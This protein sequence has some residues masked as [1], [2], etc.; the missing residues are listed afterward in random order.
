M[1]LRMYTR[2]AV[3]RGFGVEL[4]HHQEGAEAG[5]DGAVIRVDGE[6]AYAWLRGETGVHRIARVSPFGTGD[7]R[8]TSFAAVEV[9]PDVDEVAPPEIKDS[10]LRAKAICAGGPGGQ[11][12]NKV[13]TAIR[14]EHLPTG[15]VVL[16]RSERSH[17]QNRANALRLLQAKLAQID[18]DRRDEEAAVKRG[19]RPAIRFGHQRRS[20]VF[21]PKRLVRDERTEVVSHDLLGVLDGDLDAFLEAAMIAS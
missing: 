9:I 21:A 15:I 1:L 11:N 4:L 16:A 3:S 17:H 14:L 20:Y 13:A 2:W 18:R 8:Q 12:V 10:D 7:R 6:G 19:A 5:I